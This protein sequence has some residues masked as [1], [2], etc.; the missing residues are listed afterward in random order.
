M[1]EGVAYGRHIRSGSEGKESA[2]VPTQEFFGGASRPRAQESCVAGLGCDAVGL[3]GVCI[4]RD[5]PS[6][7]LDFRSLILDSLLIVEW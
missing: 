2:T 3:R 5:D 7:I 1:C 4:G 6:I